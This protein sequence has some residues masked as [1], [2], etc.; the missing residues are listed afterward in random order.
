MK[1]KVRV[2]IITLFS[3]SILF[4][5]LEARYVCYKYVPAQCTS[6]KKVLGTV[7][8]KAHYFNIQFIDKCTKKIEVPC[9]K[10][11]KK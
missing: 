5:E 9:K 4:I 7:D 1:K 3:T 6:E 11:K 2:I 8:G 10:K